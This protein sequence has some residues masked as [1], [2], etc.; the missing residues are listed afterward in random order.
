[1]TDKWIL[2]LIDADTASRRILSPVELDIASR[3]I[4]T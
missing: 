4:A 2:A 1:L 3:A